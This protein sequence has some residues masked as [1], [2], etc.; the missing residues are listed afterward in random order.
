MFQNI[1][2]VSILQVPNFIILLCGNAPILADE[3]DMINTGDYVIITADGATAV[4]FDRGVVPDI[5][6]TDLD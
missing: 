5:I 3:L 2:V 6:V 1:T 4:L